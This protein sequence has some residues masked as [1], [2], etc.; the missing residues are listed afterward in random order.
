MNDIRV[1]LHNIRSAHNVGS[2]F[3]TSDAGGV[4]HIYISGYT[5]CPKDKFGRLRKEIKKTALGGEF[6]VPWSKEDVFRVLEKLKKE[7]FNIVAVEQDKNSVNYKKIKKSKKM[8]LIMGNEVKGLSKQIL[9]K[10]DQVAEI[11]MKGEKESLNV[12]VAFGVVLFSII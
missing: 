2:I 8:V 6:S 12:S 7:G 4:N 1:I 10:C 9:N 5:P 3:R 11:P